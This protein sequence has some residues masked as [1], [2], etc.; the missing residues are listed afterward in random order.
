MC[1]CVLAHALFMY[2][3]CV[4]A[5]AC[6]SLCVSGA[7]GCWLEPRRRPA[8]TARSHCAPISHHDE[9]LPAGG[10]ALG[11]ALGQRLSGATPL[12]PGANI[13]DT[14]EWVMRNSPVPV[15][16]VPIYQVHACPCVRV[17]VCDG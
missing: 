17:C 4:C 7:G 5:R 13:H 11:A 10:G 1:V 15:G 9:S 6:V 14:R 3:V 8:S 16:T 2:L 12:P